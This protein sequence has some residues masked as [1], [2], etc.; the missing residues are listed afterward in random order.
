MPSF[1]IPEGL[2]RDFQSDW[3]D[4]I[5]RYEARIAHPRYNTTDTD[6]DALD[7]E[8]FTPLRAKWGLPEPKPAKVVAPAKDEVFHVGDSLYRVDP[9][10]GQA[11]PVV[12]GPKKL[13]EDVKMQISG[14]DK[15]IADHASIKK[16]YATN[17]DAKGV[18]Q[19]QSKIDDLLLAREALSAGKQAR[20]IDPLTGVWAMPQEV[21]QSALTPVPQSFQ[22]PNWSAT[23]V[24]PSGETETW[25]P[26]S[27]TKTSKASPYKTAADVKAAYRSKKISIDEAERILRE[28]FGME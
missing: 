19:A 25:T 7:N 11:T 17:N 10:T 3:A 2:I 24:K 18:A 27:R 14:I 28:Q 4:A 1:P 20:K 8:I 16:I 15:Q 13:D 5:A 26:T 6:P 21:S 22:N 9:A 23:V 12:S